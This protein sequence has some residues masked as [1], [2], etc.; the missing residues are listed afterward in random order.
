MRLIVTVLACAIAAAGPALA[1]S[2]APS[3][4]PTIDALISLKRAASPA[5][6][7]DA[8]WVAYTIRETNWDENIYETEIWL[9][10]AQL[11]STRQ[12]TNGRKSSNAPAW[13]PDGKRLAFGSDREDKRQIYL[14]DLGGGE[15]VKLTSAEESVGG[16][17]WSPDGRSIAFTSNEPRAEALKEREKKYAE[18]DVIDQDH[19]LSHLFV[20]D[21]ET[22]AIRRL[23]SGAFT[24]G[25]F[26][27]SPDSRQ[28]AFDHRINGDPA[29]GGSADIAVVTV[30]D[31][32]VR[33]LVTQDGPDANPQ[34][35]PDGTQIA[36][37]SSMASPKFFFSNR[38]TRGDSCRRWNDRQSVGWVRRRPFHRSMDAGGDLLHRGCEDVGL[39][40]PD[41][42][43]DESH[44][45]VCAFRTL[46]W[47]RLQPQCRCADRRV[48]RERRL[49]ISG[50]LRRSRKDDGPEET[51]D[52]GRSGGILAIRTD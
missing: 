26:E 39:P 34:W 42:P 40:L 44:H 12:L 5:I 29:N 31:G 1:Q 32:A 6:S 49:D 8:R 25:R 21:V 13:S 38:R 14:I 7:P 37:E 51:H 22:K 11:G 52:D 18:F 45:A 33:K 10:D 17:G 47:L 43:G 35:S 24:V 20:V 28:I 4:A 50:D 46:D 30:A 41:G 23:T 15:A 27:W 16:F 19:R 9:A 48:H 2:P 3:G 36:F